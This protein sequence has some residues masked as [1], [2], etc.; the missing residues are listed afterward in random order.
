VILRVHVAHDKTVHMMFGNNM[1]HDT[2]AATPLLISLT[3]HTSK[4]SSHQRQLHTT[5]HTVI[6]LLIIYLNLNLAGKPST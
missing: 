3:V 5:L 2:V 6:M 1:Q 4:C